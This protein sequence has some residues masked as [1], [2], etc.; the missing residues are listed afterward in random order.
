VI[1][2]KALLQEFRSAS[3][4]VFA[5]LLT[6][7]LT[8][9]LIRMLGRAAEG[10][11]DGD[12]VLVLILLTTLSSLGLLLSLTAFLSVLIVMARMWR[13]HE[14][15]VWMSSGI[16][17]YSFLRPVL[18]FSLP[19]VFLVALSGFIVTPW[20]LGQSEGL[21]QNFDAREES[22]RVAP[23]QFRDSADG[24]RVFFIENTGGEGDN[25][26]LVFSVLRASDGAES[27]LIS[28][29]GRLVFDETT[30]RPWV[31]ID[32]GSRVD[33]GGG[34]AGQVT[35]TSMRFDSQRFVLE[36]A[37]RV[38]G[39][40]PSLNA[41]PTWVLIAMDTSYAWGEIAARVGT[42]I[43]CLLF[44]A[45][46]IPMSFSNP[47]AGASIH[48]LLAFL[49]VMTANNLLAVVQSSISQ[50]RISFEMGWWPLHLGLLLVLLVMFL[51]RS[52][53][54]RGVL[55]WPWFMWRRLS[56]QGARIP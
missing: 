16:G 48:L 54:R 31:S 26:G 35:V 18:I 32:E 40:T 29:G 30:K 21:S 3:S 15:V 19:F 46:A 51:W 1:F 42:P 52:R 22:K 33:I 38:T 17:L 11:A 14:I 10:R 53:P 49:L 41:T 55:E 36:S 27:I 50:G 13:D 23:G 7:L 8:T 24:Q 45:L 5:S 28:K 4:I 47:R 43:L 2:Q 39:S 9:T 44:S 12:L 25:L 34:G 37:P 20:A 6:I 56:I